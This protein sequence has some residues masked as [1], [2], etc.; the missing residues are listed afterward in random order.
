[1]PT[2]KTVF[3][4]DKGKLLHYEKYQQMKKKQ[5]KKANLSLSFL[6]T[7]LQCIMAAYNL[8]LASHISSQA[9]LLLPTRAK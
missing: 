5:T 2:L 4:K 7:A 9:Q 6:I 1:M 3:Q 8:L